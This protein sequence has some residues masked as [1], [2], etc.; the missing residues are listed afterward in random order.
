MVTQTPPQ[1]RWRGPL[2]ISLVLHLTLGLAI[3]LA[4]REQRSSQ[5]VTQETPH[6]FGLARRGP[7]KP[8]HSGEEASEPL[9]MEGK[10]GFK[11]PFTIEPG[12]TPPRGHAGT[13]AASS[14]PRK[15]GG[16]TNGKGVTF[17]QIGTAA[18]RIVYVVDASASMGKDGLWDRASREIV[19][20]LERLSEEAQFQIIVYNNSARALLP[21]APGWL[22][23]TPAR[24]AEVARALYALAPEGR[25]NHA[26]ALNL[27]LSLRPEVVF[28][29]TDADDLSQALLKQVDSWNHHGAVIHAIELNRCESPRPGTPMQILAQRHRGE[30]RAVPRE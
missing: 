28:F 25:T 11:D 10:A 1:V 18:R 3:L 26:P 7:A 19:R 13:D 9:L 2:L 30:Y 24:R 4:P 5:P 22:S 12:L 16:G 21:A 14:G 23:T 27:A 20:S 17:F 8:A 15:A 29:L 6:R